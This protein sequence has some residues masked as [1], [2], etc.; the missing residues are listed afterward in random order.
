MKLNRDR[1]FFRSRVQAASE[2]WFKRAIIGQGED[3]KNGTVTGQSDFFRTQKSL[4]NFCK[5]LRP[6]WLPG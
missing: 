3:S 1:S 4:K 2:R 6:K 5:S